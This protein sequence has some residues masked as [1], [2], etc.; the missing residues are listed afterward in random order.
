MTTY[1]RP[2]TKAEL[3][4]HLLGQHLQY[5]DDHHTRD[6]LD[7]LHMQAHKLADMRAQAVQPREIVCQTCGRTFVGR[8]RARRCSR[9]CEQQAYRARKK[10]KAS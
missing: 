10:E 6:V 5:V 7:W 4:S 8:G 1:H 3:W 2:R 9:N